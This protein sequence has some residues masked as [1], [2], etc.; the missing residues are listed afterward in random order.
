MDL[1][2]ARRNMSTKELWKLPV[3]ST[4]LVEEPALTKLPRRHYALSLKWE[5]DGDEIVGATIDFVDVEAYRVTHLY[6]LTDE[7]IRTAY[8]RLVEFA[9]SDWLASSTLVHRRPAGVRLRHARIC[10][11]DGPCYEFLCA[12]VHVR[13]GAN[14]G[15]T[16]L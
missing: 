2:G 11:D 5:G 16:I 4:A 10:F 9:A 7:M 13:S 8:D 1:R 6:S 3:S 12:D 14:T 15:N